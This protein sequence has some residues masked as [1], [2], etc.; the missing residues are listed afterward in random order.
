MNELHKLEYSQN[1]LLIGG[2]KEVK[3]FSDSEIT[4]SLDKVA[5]RL[6]GKGFKIVEV[7]LEKGILKAEGTLLSLNYGGEVKEGFL[8]RLF[9]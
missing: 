3:E 8:K 6:L 5:L 4:L 1:S 7:D 2:V 9:K